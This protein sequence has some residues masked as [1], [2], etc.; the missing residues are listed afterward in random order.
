M[1][2]TPFR[3]LAT[4]LFAFLFLNLQADGFYDREEIQPRLETMECIVKPRYTTAVESYIKGYFARDGYKAKLILARTVTFF[5]IFE[6][7]LREHNMP[8]D[9]KY[10]AVV[11]SALNP[12]A[13]S[14]VGATGLWQ[15]MKET[16]I[17]YGLK[18]NSRI[19][20]RSCPN[21]STI[22]AMEYLSKAYKRFGSW[23]LA[24]ASYN[25]GAGNVRRAMRRAGG[26][27]DYWKISR[28]LPRET[29]N[30]V[31]AFLGAAYMVKYYDK[32]GLTPEYR[33]LDLQL[34]ESELIYN[35][36]EFETIAAIAGVPVSIV[37]AL[38]P[39]YKKGYVPANEK[40]HWVILP[41]R[42]MQALRDYVKLLKPENSETNPL[43][44]LPELITEEN[45]F[46]S[47]HY[48]K[49][50]YMTLQD[51]QL[52]ELGKLF[53][54][55]G[56]NLKVWNSLESEQLSRK[57]ELVVWFPKELRRYQPFSE[58]VEVLPVAAQLP[59]EV[60]NVRPILPKIKP[61][62]PIKL[63]PIPV[64]PHPHLPF[65]A[66]PLQAAEKKLAHEQKEKKLDLQKMKAWVA[67]KSFFQEEEKSKRELVL[68]ELRI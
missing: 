18:I 62:E 68:G 25:C 65:T 64:N 9:L 66:M 24:I 60:K 54:C 22:A 58:K 21:R 1:D 42:S 2:R 46:P 4:L 49:S 28:Y 33:H 30:F 63:T 5:P 55:S 51:D 52:F 14:R 8:D 45:Y 12:K 48:Y 67:E 32:H 27:K 39:A 56:Y 31:P 61:I 53:K 57:Q 17:G 3:T 11:E 50:F 41:R 7:Y 40:G 35:E 59:K 19:D 36:M 43:P 37:E 10:L 23:E 34:T 29:R 15:F 47:D 13:V 38:N 44:E 6:K 20:E 16:G 26:S